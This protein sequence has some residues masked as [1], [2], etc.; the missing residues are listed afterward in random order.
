MIC[1]PESLVVDPGL[2]QLN[3]Q[4]SIM[5]VCISDTYQC[6]GIGDD[7]GLILRLCHIILISCF[8]GCYVKINLSFQSTNETTTLKLKRTFA[9][10]VVKCG[11]PL[12]V[13]LK[14]FN[15]S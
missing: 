14:P 8:K 2:Y 9:H 1:Q 3:N 15:D 13:P 6:L 10:I 4:G 7:A 12:K 5:D 11:L